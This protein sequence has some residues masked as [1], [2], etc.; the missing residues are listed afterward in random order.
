MLTEKMGRSSRKS[1]N[2]SQE[3]FRDRS[4]SGEHKG[5]I[6]IAIDDF[7]KTSTKF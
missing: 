3:A 6:W 7:G 5:V 2:N 4:M 1:K